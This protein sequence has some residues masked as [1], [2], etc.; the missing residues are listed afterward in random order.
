VEVKEKSLAPAE[1]VGGFVS[2][3]AHAPW[4]G[5]DEWRAASARNGHKP[6]QTGK[7]AGAQGRADFEGGHRVTG[8]AEVFGGAFFGNLCSWIF[9]PFI[10]GC[11]KRQTHGNLTNFLRRVFTTFGRGRLRAVDSLDLETPGF[12][13]VSAIHWALVVQRACGV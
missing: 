7:A 11:T 3:G 8:I 13:R 9:D 4:R 5:V 2:R 10:L 12:R 6:T 1:G